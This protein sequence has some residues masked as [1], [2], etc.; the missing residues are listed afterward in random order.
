MPYLHVLK[1]RPLSWFK[2]RNPTRNQPTVISVCIPD[3]KKEHNHFCTMVVA[4]SDGNIKS[5]K[6]RVLQN[7]ITKNWVADAMS[8]AVDITWI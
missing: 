6:A 2:R 5:L 4:Y 3:L 1:L 7:S 8:V